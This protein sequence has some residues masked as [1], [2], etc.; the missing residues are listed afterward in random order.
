MKNHI[1]TSLP[2]S[3]YIP[4]AL[5][6]FTFPAPLPSFSHQDPSCIVPPQSIAWPNG[7]RICRYVWCVG[8]VVEKDREFVSAEEGSRRNSPSSY[9]RREIATLLARTLL[10]H[11]WRSPNLTTM[12]IKASGEESGAVGGVAA[13]LG[14]GRKWRVCVVFE[15]E[16]G[17]G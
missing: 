7:D 9:L 3:V 11:R 5:F 8:S 1:K 4:P 17:V 15:E 12:Q 16:E 10:P 6:P 13:A 2:L 14:G